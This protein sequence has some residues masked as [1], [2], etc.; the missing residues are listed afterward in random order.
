MVCGKIDRQKTV[1]KCGYADRRD[2]VFNYIHAKKHSW[3]AVP[4]VDVETVSLIVA[5]QK[6]SDMSS[7]LLPPR[8]P[9][10]W[11]FLRKVYITS[12]ILHL[13][14]CSYRAGQLPVSV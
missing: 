8:P 2:E 3:T 6:H 14:E 1:E 5:E 10:R 12:A 13:C 11:E 9:K 4:P 7:R